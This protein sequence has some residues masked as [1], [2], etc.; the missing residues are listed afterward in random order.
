MEVVSALGISE[1]RE[2][3]VGKYAG[4]PHHRNLGQGHRD[5]PEKVRH[6]TETDVIE[7]DYLTNDLG[8]RKR[9]GLLFIRVAVFGLDNPVIVEI[10]FT[11]WLQRRKA[12][13]PAAW[14]KAA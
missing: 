9:S 8:A 5:K 11:Q 2:R 1:T 6:E 10:P 13:H 3:V 7:P 4:R 14:A 12:Y